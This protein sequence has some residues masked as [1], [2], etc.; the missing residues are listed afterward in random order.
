MGMKIVSSNR[1]AGQGE[2]AV[3]PELQHKSGVICLYENTINSGR[4]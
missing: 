3:S 4:N 2:E 1:L